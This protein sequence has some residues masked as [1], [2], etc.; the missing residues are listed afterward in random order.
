MGSE[1]IDVQ[2]RSENKYEKKLNMGRLFLNKNSEEYRIVNRILQNHKLVLFSKT[3]CPYCQM[4][5][6]ILKNTGYKY[7]TVELDKRSKGDI[8]EVRNQNGA[9]TVSG[10]YV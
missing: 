4:T 3:Y 6:K 10:V 7:H 8:E 2:C 5:K 9:P 1:L